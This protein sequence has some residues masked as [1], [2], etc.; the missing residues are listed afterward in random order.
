MSDP[1]KIVLTKSALK[2]FERIVLD[3]EARTIEVSG[4]GHRR[5]IYDE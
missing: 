4:V 2:N 1:Y 3:K 5:D